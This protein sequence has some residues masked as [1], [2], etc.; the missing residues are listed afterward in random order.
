MTF[1]GFRYAEL[2]GWPGDIH[3]GDIVAVAISSDLERIGDFSCS[4]PLLTT[5]HENA[6]RSARGNFI[7]LPTDCPQRDER[8][9]WTG[10]LAL[11]APAALT[12]FDATDFL[13][14][15]LRDLRAE[16][17]AA[18]GAVPWVVPD[19]LKFIESPPGIPINATT[20]IWGDAA[21]WVPWAI[22]QATGNTHVLSLIHI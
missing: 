11:F 18:G 5:L 3:P 16:Q 14:D 12:L 17:A 8:L 7:D 20:A 1:H 2:V 15:W 4:N 9:G 19:L 10:D 22:W 6:A 21:V 13:R